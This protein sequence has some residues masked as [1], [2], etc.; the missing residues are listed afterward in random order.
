M[1]DTDILS[2]LTRNPEGAASRRVQSLPRRDLCTS[3][4]A[5]AEL[6]F[7]DSKQPNLERGRRNDALLARIPVQSF[8]QPADLRYAELRATLE[9]AGTPIGQNDMLIAAQ[10]LALD[11]TLVSGNEREFRRVPG[12]KVENWLAG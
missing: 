3:I 9:R 10:A 8:E 11:V 7:G 2:D 5:A 6:R 12:L 1:L 4:I